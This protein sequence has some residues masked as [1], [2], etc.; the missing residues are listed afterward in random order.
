MLEAQSAATLSRK[1]RA[2]GR[3]L[4][5]VSSST[6]RMTSSR[7]RLTRKRASFS[8]SRLHVSSCDSGNGADLRMGSDCDRCRSAS[9]FP[10]RSP[11]AGCADPR[12]GGRVR[13]SAP[14]PPCSVL[15][16]YEALRIA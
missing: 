10:R 15:T 7:D 9:V 8:A 4:S 13:N 1:R 14:E 16:P 5:Q 11:G 3:S 6:K 12:S 2:W